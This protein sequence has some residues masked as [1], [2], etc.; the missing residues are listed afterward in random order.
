VAS[1]LRLWTMKQ[2]LQLRL[3]KSWLVQIER[4]DYS[5]ANDRHPTVTRSRT[6]MT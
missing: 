6:H 4:S 5:V 2:L 1:R 3:A